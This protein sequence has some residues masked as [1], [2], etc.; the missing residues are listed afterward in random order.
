V[1]KSV[2]FQIFHEFFFEKTKIMKSFYRA[3]RRRIFLSLP[4]HLC[5]HHGQGAHDRAGSGRCH[6]GAAQISDRLS[7]GQHLWF[8]PLN[9][10]KFG[11]EVDPIFILCYVTDLN[12]KT[13][14]FKF[15]RSEEKHFLLMESGIRIHLTKYSREKNN[16]PNGF[17]MKLRKH[18][19]TKLLHDIQ[20]MGSDRV[21]ILTF[22]SGENAFHVILELYA[23]GNIILTDF[24]FT[25]LSLLRPYELETDSIRVAVG[26]KFP[27]NFAP[28]PAPIDASSLTALWKKALENPKNK[29]IADIF[30]PGS[31]FSPVVIEHCLQQAGVDP[32][33]NLRT[34]WS[35]QGAFD[36]CDVLVDALS[37]ALPL[38]Q[39]IAEQPLKGYL[40]VQPP[41]AI[42]SKP[43]E[44]PATEPAEPEMNY[45][46]FIPY[47][48]SGMQKL[49]TREFPTFNEAVDEFFTRLEASKESARLVAQE[50][51]AWSKVE[52]IRDDHQQR[53]SQLEQAQHSAEHKA[54]LVEHHHEMIDQAMLAVRQALAA[55]M[56][57]NALSN[58]IREERR[59][60]NPVA[61]WIKELKLE[62]NKI[63]LAVPNQLPEDESDDSESNSDSDSNESKSD[64]EDESD[65]EPASKKKAA[66]KKHAGKPAKVPF[67]NIDVDLS[68]TANANASTI[69]SSKKKSADK[70]QVCLLFS[71]LM[72]FTLFQFFF[73]HHQRTEA[74]TSKALKAAEVNT[75]KTLAALEKQQRIAK[76][77]K[78]FWFE[79][80]HWFI[81]SE[82]YLV[83]GGKDA[84]QNET[85]V[86]RYLK[87]HDAYIHADIHGASSVI[88]KNSG[89]GPIPPLSLQ[90]ASLMTISRSSA[91][92]A[93]V[94]TTAYWVNAHQ[95]SK[96]APSGEY[97]G[98]GS[99]MIRGK[100]NLI[101]AAPLVMGLGILF[102]LD[103]ST[104]AHHIGER[105][106]RGFG[107]T[108][109]RD[110]LESIAD[111]DVGFAKS[112]AAPLPEEE[113]SVANDD[114]PQSDHDD[115]EAEAEAEAEEAPTEAAQPAL[116]SDSEDEAPAMDVT[117]ALFASA[118]NMPQVFN[119]GVFRGAAS[120][121]SAS[122]TTT[123]PSASTAAS[124]KP[125]S[126]DSFAAAMTAVS[127][128]TAQE[129]AEA[130]V[131]L[132]AA[133]STWNP[134]AALAEED[135]DD[136]F[137]A[138]PSAANNRRRLT[139]AQRRYM[140]KHGSLDGF[141]EKDSDDDVKPEP[142]AAPAA[143]PAEKP[144]AAKTPSLA[145]LPRGKVLLC[146]VIFCSSNSQFM[147]YL[148]CFL[149]LSVPR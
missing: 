97:L 145:S 66:Q 32:K 29:L 101:P 144:A 106:V 122:S 5:S 40:V 129:R 79:K 30:P 103:P 135:P 24:E 55:G 2:R 64:E 93:K 3:S 28:Q 85:L 58:L 138:Q 26:E 148:N 75:R 147:A 78:V 59:Q 131:M 149:Y 16:T 57:W 119:L 116:S 51:A 34:L 68:L 25:I 105:R 87:K 63:T 39:C 11:S 38:L 47:L 22:G 84:Q 43:A 35:G 15:A 115:A 18:I 99:F 142:V 146:V 20:Q 56:D 90:Q 48:F 86:K 45:S 67:V 134:D 17:C 42:K 73:Y 117:S 96:T 52:R 7:L 74:A 76:L 91:W 111:S 31:P 126:G 71:R 13:F 49:Q 120:T 125:S 8:D 89:E 88:V 128:G 1:Q 19:R 60:G 136:P 140:K 83:V 114:D 121:P 100:R 54:R 92:E 23:G 41:A 123:T 118:N 81:T 65:D 9:L 141:G 62:Q 36:N 113:E 137:A 14:L 124:V 33:S 37:A 107:D 133:S 61:T 12:P 95:V 98:T 53:I 44:V 139:A 127:G 6:Q 10:W 130:R 132:A 108:T 94:L 82:N 110:D 109:D 102:R 69:F 72:F 143:A 27:V 21:L 50:A 104:M 112:A 77:R 46:E 4:L 70:Q 80:F